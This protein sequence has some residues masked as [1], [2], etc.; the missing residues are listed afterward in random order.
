MATT[1]LSRRDVLALSAAA[2]AAYACGGAK[3]P[4]NESLDLDADPLALLPSSSVA[5][6][7]L[8]ARAFY[9]S[10]TVGARIAQLSERLVPVGDESG[11]SASRDVDRVTLACYATGGLEAAAVVSGRFDPDRIA[12]SAS[13]NTITR[14]GAPLV[15]STYAGR[16]L[17]TVANVG[18]CVLTPK[19]AVAGTEWGIR[20]TLEKIES[21]QLVRAFKPWMIE[22]VHAKDAAATAAIDLEDSDVARA[23]V[24]AVPLP[25]ASGMRLARVVGNFASPG[26]HIALR[27][28]YVD[29]QT[30]QT[31][32]DGL[33]NLNA[34]GSFLLKLSDVDVQT[35]GA[36]VTAKATVDDS[37]LDWLLGLVQ[38]LVPTAP[39]GAT[40]A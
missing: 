40:P 14:L 2:L 30:A 13:N 28:S 8:D 37:T 39:A 7:A 4:D 10:N 12:R 16:T 32:A 1:I 31:A 17:Y 24:A 20:R 5:L 23:A 15:V 35:D 6:S 22:T 21:K 9:A 3:S 19:T 29:A 26:M 36:D 11:F 38:K 18:F 27:L 33:R 25:G 34:I